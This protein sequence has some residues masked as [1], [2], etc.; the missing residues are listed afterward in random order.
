MHFLIFVSIFSKTCVKMMHKYLNVG[1]FTHKRFYNIFSGNE[2]KRFCSIYLDT[3]ACFHKVLSVSIW[4]PSRIKTAINVISTLCSFITICWNVNKETHMFY[5]HEEY[6]DNM[7]VLF[8]FIHE[9][10]IMKRDTTYF[11]DSKS[12]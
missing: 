4:P 11:H 8:S 5:N 12:T 6:E 9:E 2:L 7:N 3:L 10:K 1:R